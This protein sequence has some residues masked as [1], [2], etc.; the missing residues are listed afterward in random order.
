LPKTVAIVD[1]PTG[2][3]IDEHDCFTSAKQILNPNAPLVR[4]AAAVKDPIQT[5]LVYTVKSLMK[6]ELQ[7]YSWR[8]ATIATVNKISSINEAVSDTPPQNKAGLI[9]ANE[10]WNKRLESLRQNLGNSFD[11]QVLKG[12]RPNILRF[13]SIFFLRKKNKVGSVQTLNVSGVGMKGVE[14]RVKS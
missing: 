12:N 11:G 5:I 13:S 10:Q 1:P 7:N 8:V 6:V 9:S 14:E 2:D 3:T 4:E